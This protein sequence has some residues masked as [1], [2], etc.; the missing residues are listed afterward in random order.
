MGNEVTNSKTST[1]ILRPRTLMEITTDGGI[2]IGDFFI[3]PYVSIGTLIGIPA[4]TLFSI[5]IR[6]RLDKKKK[7]KS[8]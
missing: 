6:R 3:A 5:A 4:G 8:K 1:L 2:W 7:R